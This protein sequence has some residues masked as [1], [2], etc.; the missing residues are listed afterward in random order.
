MGIRVRYHPLS[1]TWQVSSFRGVHYKTSPGGTCIAN[2]TCY[3]PQGTPYAVSIGQTST[4]TGLNV[5]ESYNTRLQPG[6]IKAQV[7]GSN[8]VIDITYNFVDP[9]STHNAGHVYGITNNIDNAR[10]QT[11]TYD[12]LNRIVSAQTTST[13]ATAPTKCWGEVYTLDAWANLNSIAATTNS[14][15]TGC[16]QESGFSQTAGTNNRLPNFGYDAAGNTTS[17]GVNSYTWDAESQMKTAAGVTYGYDGQGRRA[18]KSSGKLYWYGSGGEILAETNSSGGT[19]AEYIFFG[20]K[21]IAMLPATGNAQF[22]VEDMLGSSRIVTTNAGVVCYDADFYPYGGE[23]TP[24]TNNCPTSNNY[25]FEG[26]ER[27]TETGND[28][29]GARYYSNRFGR[30]LSADWSA[31]PAPVPYANLTNPQTL[32][33]YSMVGDDPESFADLDGHMRSDMTG[34]VVHGNYIDCYMCITLASNLTPAEMDTLQQQAAQSSQTPQTPA[35]ATQQQPAY[36][37]PE[38]AIVNHIVNFNNDVNAS[39][40]ADLRRGSS[41]DK[42]INR[43]LHTTG[44]DY[45]EKRDLVWNKEQDL[46]LRD[47]KLEI[48]LFVTNTVSS[49]RL[50]EFLGRLDRIQ[51]KYD[52]ANKL[53][54]RVLGA[55]GAIISKLNPWAGAT[56]TAVK[57]LAPTPGQVQLLEFGKSAVYDQ[58]DKLKADP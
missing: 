50:N 4:F 57:V 35:Q 1:Y 31:V 18:S 22:Y 2:V 39:T 38:D 25:K 54:N 29:F 44:L 41:S 23:R 49:G 11:F 34:E 45:Q 46:H 17:D 27:D 7:S 6:E 40:D 12:Q 19:T 8:P 13:F 36:Q 43:Y 47:V 58:L 37:A 20:G 15:Y 52:E 28:D 30:W 24:Y 32:N 26:K 42:E 14:A 51:H 56:V 9:A 21:R 55:V 16:T 10:S 33:L 53:G 3:A 5:T 48:S